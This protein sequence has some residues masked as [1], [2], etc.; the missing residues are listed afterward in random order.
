MKVLSTAFNSTLRFIARHVGG[1]YKRLATF[2]GI[3][4][5]VAIAVA[6]LFGKLA[7]E[8]REGETQIF[9]ER[10]LTWFMQHRSPV[11]DSI[12]LELTAVGDMASLTVMVL[13]AAGL[14]WLTKNRDALALLLIG[15]IGGSALNTV[16]KGAFAR[17]RPMI[18]EWVTDVQTTSFPS[19]HAMTSFAAFGALAYVMGRIA[20]NRR[21]RLIVWSAAA[22]M[23]VII[24]VSRMY[25]GVHYPTDIAA[26]YLAGLAWLM[27]VAGCRTALRYFRA[28][29]RMESPRS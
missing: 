14:L 19:G 13:V 16:L 17:P 29:R 10:I 12:M 6:F 9:D 20:P 1:V 11:L 27:F 25:L 24:G 21:V 4:F 22:F 8:V 26:G 5:V 7:H 15:T 23:I 18:V 28:R 2:V 3:G